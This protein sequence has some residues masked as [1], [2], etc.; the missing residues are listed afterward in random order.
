VK[1]VEVKAHICHFPLPT[2]FYPTWM[3]GLPQYANSCVIWR[4][5]T[6]EGVEG[7]S[8]GVALADESKGMGDLARIALLGRDPMRPEEIFKTLRSSTRVLGMRAWSIEPALWDIIGKVS[9]QPLWRLLGGAH[10]ALPAYASTGELHPAA[11]R[12]EEVLAIKEAGFKGVKLRL[13]MPTVAEDVAIVR[14]V[15]EAAGDEMTI[16]VDANQGWK[17]HGFGHKPDWDLGRAVATARALEE[18]DV[19]WLEEPLDQHDYDGYRLLRS[20]TAL[21]IAGGEMISDLAGLRDLI[22][23]G[24][25]DVVQPDATLSGGIGL[26]RKVAGMAEAHGLSFSPHTWTNGLGLVI[27]LHVAASCPVATW[28]EFPFDPP[29]W[30][31]EVRDAMLSEPTQLGPDGLIAPPAEPGL[32]VEL[33]MEAVSAYGKEI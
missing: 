15:R 30:V 17:I 11:Q 7:I 1:I 28:F 23:G 16:M 22:G 25:V 10:E 4:L 12:A 6:D 9:G 5:I 14:A 21:R 18:L 31:P 19:F 2:P 26:S 24:C 32:G 33:N 13:G 8:A 29:A 3:P 20:K 27:N